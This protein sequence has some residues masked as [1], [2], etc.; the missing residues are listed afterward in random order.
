[1]FRRQPRAIFIKILVVCWWV[2]IAQSVWRL[3]TETGRSGDRIPVGARFSAAVQTG[4]PSLLY[5]G[6]RV[7]FL[8]VKRPGRGV[9][10]PPP[11]S[12]EVKERVGLY[13]YFPFGSL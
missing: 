12:T 1:M 8:R 3:S 5:S 7:F 13:L 10:H 2:V 11:S 9:I 6:Y 4:P